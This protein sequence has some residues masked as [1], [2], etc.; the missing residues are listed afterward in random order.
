MGMSSSEPEPS[1]NKRRRGF[2]Q[3]LFNISL[4]VMAILVGGFVV[5][6][7]TTRSGTLITIDREEAAARAQLL[8]TASEIN[9]SAES[10]D[11]TVVEILNGVG[12][13]GLA[14]EF[15]DF[16]RSEGYDVL[17]FTNAQRYDYPRTLVINRGNNLKRAQFVAQSLGLDPSDIENI[18][19][20]DVQ[21]DVTIVIGEDYLTLSSYRKM[22]SS[23]R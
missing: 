13:P 12:L 10:D 8:T 23:P 17:R 11:R 19:D 7:F 4:I 3:W 14:G 16:I 5:S 1:W 21:I 22:Q 20:P 9:R 2:Q 18:L 6:A 15:S